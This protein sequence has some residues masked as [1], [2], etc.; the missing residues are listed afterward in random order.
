[1][2]EL[3][4]ARR[5]GE[6]IHYDESR[7]GNSGHYYIDRDG[8]VHQYVGVERIAHHTGQPFEKV[9]K[10]VKDGDRVTVLPQGGRE[11]LEPGPGAGEVHVRR[12]DD[13]RIAGRAAAEKAAAELEFQE[14]A[15][16][17]H[18]GLSATKMRY[19]RALDKL[20][21]KFAGIAET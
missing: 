6:R 18:M 4:T 11:G 9:T 10:D 7:T 2:P 14:I 17:M 1:M 3:A 15:D 21:E 16:I 12:V 19:K 13:E 20:R 5:F 8:A